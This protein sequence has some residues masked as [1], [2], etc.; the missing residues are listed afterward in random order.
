MGRLESTLAAAA[1]VWLIGLSPAGEPVFGR[2]V[3]LVVR[4]QKVS[5]EAGK[6]ALLP[7]AA[8]LT[9]GDAV[10]LYEKAVKALPGKAVSDQIQQWL[11]MPIEQLPIDPV[12]EALEQYI[13]SFK[14]VAQA[15]KCRECKWPA[16]TDGT[17][18][19]TGGQYRQL[20]MALGLWARYE[21]AQENYEGALLAL[22]AGLGMGRHLMQEGPTLTDFL[23]GN[24]VAAV[25]CMEVGEFVQA[26]EAPNLYAALAALPRPFIDVEKMIE[27]AKKAIPSEPPVGVTRAQFESELKRLQTS[28]DR[29]R[30]FVKRLDTDWAALQCV[31][32]IRS[33]AAS[34]GWQLPQTLA[35][36]TEVSLP[37]DPMSC[38]GFR[39]T[40]TRA[41]AVLESA[42]PAGG[43]AEDVTR[44]EITVKN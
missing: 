13:G 16:S 26:A 34:H 41:V 31:E 29:T 38:A 2:E 37:K 35:E 25:M 9:D 8:S 22:R 40:R 36:I 21:I 15:V 18:V 6:Y 44:Y 39:Y 42:K 14:G 23:T 20:G 33:Y 11:K 3:K 1:F 24:M 43:G 17:P 12:G 19:A 4:P 27:S 32:A 7:P 5:A 30:I 28:Y 10:P